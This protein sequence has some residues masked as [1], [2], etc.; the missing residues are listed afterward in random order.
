VTALFAGA[1]L[2]VASFAA[3]RCASARQYRRD[4]EQRAAALQSQLVE[5]EQALRDSKA[6]DRAWLAV[7]AHELRS[8]VAAIVGY[9]ELL[10]DGMF[11][12]IPERGSEAISRINLAAGQ[13]LQ[14]TEAV[15]LIAAEGDDD[16][17]PPETVPSLELLAAAANSL[18][19]DADA[20]GANI[21]IAS[22]DLHIR[23]RRVDAQRTL[24]LAIG[25]A[26]KVSGE[27]TITLCAVDGVTGVR[28]VVR[29][30]RLDTD[31]DEPARGG[32][33][34]TGAGFRI[35]LARTAAARV[36]G[37]V[38]LAHSAD[39]TELHVELPHLSD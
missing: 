6:R 12:P 38:A 31:A 2:L 26:V 8:P 23:T 37:S 5:A 39:G 29:G 4:A 7:L 14:L 20:R 15:E 9:G 10:N 3:I 19:F 27:S 21:V 13:I 28:F 32:Q 18:R 17:D 34:L 1:A 33:R 30:S 36:G 11:G 22:D 25:A 16:P 24:I 35:A